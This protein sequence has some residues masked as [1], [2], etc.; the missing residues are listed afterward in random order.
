VD[1][2]TRL[3]HLTRQQARTLAAVAVTGERSAAG[4]LLG[5]SARTVANHLDLAFERLDVQSVTAAFRALG[6]LDPPLELL[7]VEVPAEPLPFVWIGGL[8]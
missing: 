4:R 5:V 2:D 7:Q 6:W 8:S 3:I 1:P